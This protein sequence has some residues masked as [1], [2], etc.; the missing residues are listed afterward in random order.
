[1]N[2]SGFSSKRNEKAG[3]DDCVVGLLCFPVLEARRGEARRGQE[4]RWPTVKKRVMEGPLKI[5]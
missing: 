1:M 3:P 4:T 2:R 5:N